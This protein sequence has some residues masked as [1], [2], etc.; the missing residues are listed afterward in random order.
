ML[1]SHHFIVV[2]LLA[3]TGGGVVTVTP[4]VHTL[5]DLHSGQ[6]RQEQSLSLLDLVPVE[7]DDLA[8]D[9]GGVAGGDVGVE[10]GLF[11]LLSHHHGLGVFQDLRGGQSLTAGIELTDPFLRVEGR[12]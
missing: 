3:A 8:A 6:V 2:R 5:V 7:G 9:G 10:V 12:I 1:E 11:L 4:Q